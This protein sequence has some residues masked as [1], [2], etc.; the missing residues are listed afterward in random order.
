M[1]IRDSSDALA[2]RAMADYFLGG[3]RK[4]LD[5]N[6][7]DIVGDLVDSD[8]PHFFDG[9]NARYLPMAR[10]IFQHPQYEKLYR[11]VLEGTIDANMFQERGVE[12]LRRSLIDIL[13]NPDTKVAAIHDVVPEVRNRLELVNE[14]PEMLRR[15]QESA[16]K[17]EA[18]EPIIFFTGT[19]VD[20]S[21]IHISEPTSPY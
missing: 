10:K 13:R 19:E 14:T 2:I 8:I 12:L 20:L 1:C 16:F 5:D 9:S 7:D 18:G 3:K 15:L 6:R 4:L 21:L 17:N 11:E